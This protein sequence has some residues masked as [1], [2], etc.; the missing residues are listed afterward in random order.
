MMYMCIQMTKTT[1]MTKIQEK[2]KKVMVMMTEMITGKDMK[3]E[4]N[5]DQYYILNTYMKLI[6][7][8]TYTKENKA[9]P[10]YQILK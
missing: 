3:L 9:L 6:W 5:P 2:M 4:G 7:N 10:I 1:N 8:M